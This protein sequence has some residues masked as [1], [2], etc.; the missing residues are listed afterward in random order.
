MKKL[1]LAP[2][3]LVVLLSAAQPLWANV[4][5]CT[6]EPLTAVIDFDTVK[7][8]TFTVKFSGHVIS[9]GDLMIASRSP[10]GCATISGTTVTF[11]KPGVVTVRQPIDVDSEAKS[12]GESPPLEPT[13][14]AKAVQVE[15][16]KYDEKMLVEGKFDL[17][18]EG[19][20]ADEDTYSWSFTGAGG[21]DF[22]P[23]PSGDGKTKFKATK[24]TSKD[25]ESF[26]NVK[27]SVAN[28][29]E[30]VKITRCEYFKRE[31]DIPRSATK[32]YPDSRD[33]WTYL[34]GKFS[35]RNPNRKITCI[36]IDFEYHLYD[37][38]KEA[39]F[40]SEHGD[41]FSYVKEYKIFYANDFRANFKISK[42]WGYVP[43]SFVDGI[44]FPTRYSALFP[45]SIPLIRDGKL[46]C[47]VTLDW[48]ASVQE[49]KHE[50]RIIRHSGAF[51]YE[52]V[53]KNPRTGLVSFNIRSGYKREGNLL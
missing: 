44:Y 24:I 13:A 32:V 29:K 39:L 5:N 14:E 26:I 8:V 21:G 19:K 6:I 18:A 30:E 49:G 1:I 34:S 12:L 10:E 20:P 38:Y 27:Y 25:S 37:Q 43:D 7:T 52:N 47:L 23:N 28:A 2:V 50:K 48:A 9:A 42:D 31:S 17:T 53:R 3:I 15:I 4:G 36:E 35:S 51:Y 16:T 46:A 41:S 45:E 11:S 33:Y 22:V 40:D